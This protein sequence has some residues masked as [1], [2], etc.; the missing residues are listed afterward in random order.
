MVTE[1]GK[2]KIW[3]G[4]IICQDQ[5]A[6]ALKLTSRESRRFDSVLY[7]LS[8]TASLQYWH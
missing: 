2:G 3:F 5:G 4:K 8:T 6:Q 7:N 1:M